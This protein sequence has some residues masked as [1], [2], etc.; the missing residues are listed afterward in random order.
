[1]ANS[2]ISFLN[3]SSFFMS[4]YICLICFS[5]WATLYSTFP[6]LASSYCLKLSK[7]F[8]FFCS[9]ASVDDY[10]EERSLLVLDTEAFKSLI[11]FSVF[12]A[13][14]DQFSELDFIS[15]Y[16]FYN[17]LIYSCVYPS[18]W[19]NA[20]IFPFIVLTYS[21]VFFYSSWSFWMLESN[22][23]TFFFWEPMNSSICLLAAARSSFKVF[24]P[25]FNSS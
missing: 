21:F 18:T 13:F 17:Y 3:F 10:R 7:S 6:T 22:C 9:R 2:R 23:W 14:L 4:S 5:A 1:M 25:F 8:S 11:S 12:S 15:F 24:Y 16:S 20:F 19:L